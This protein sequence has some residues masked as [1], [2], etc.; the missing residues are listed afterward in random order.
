MSVRSESIPQVAWSE[1]RATDEMSL[2]MVGIAV[3]QKWVAL[4][5]LVMVMRPGRAV[6]I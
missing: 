2:S 4:M 6:R 5:G 3:S 1:E